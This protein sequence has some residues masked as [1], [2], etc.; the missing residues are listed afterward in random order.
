MVISKG[1][2]EISFLAQ[3]I[4]LFYG[5]EG[6][7]PLPCTT[8][9]TE[10]RFVNKDPVQLANQLGISID[11]TVQVLLQIRFIFLAAL[12]ALDLPS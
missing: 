8:F 1:W 11:A 12:A 9:Q 2:Y 5:E 7:C 6:S 10:T 3:I 4:S